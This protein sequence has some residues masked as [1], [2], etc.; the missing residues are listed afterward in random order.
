MYRCDPF[1]I[2]LGGERRSVL[3]INNAKIRGGGTTMTEN[4][5]KGAP[6]GNKARPFFYRSHNDKS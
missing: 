4:D 5:K 2:M 6:A 1:A 3:D